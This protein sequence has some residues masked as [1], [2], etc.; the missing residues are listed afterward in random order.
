MGRARISTE[1]CKYLL[2][3]T[4]FFY[5]EKQVKKEKKT[6]RERERKRETEKKKKKFKHLLLLTVPIDG[7]VKKKNKADFIFANWHFC[8]VQKR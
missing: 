2:L 6:D 8:F 1:L 4:P 7:F 3:S 5:K